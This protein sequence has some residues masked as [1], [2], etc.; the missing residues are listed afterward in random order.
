MVLVG[1]AAKEITLNTQNM[2][3]RRITLS[4]SLGATKSDLDEVLKLIASK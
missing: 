2:I 1:L 4:G 3:M